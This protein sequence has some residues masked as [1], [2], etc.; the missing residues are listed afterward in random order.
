MA[1]V[2]NIDGQASS[3]AI[4]RDFLV[5]RFADVLEDPDTGGWTVL[6]P[7]CDSGA[8]VSIARTLRA[9]P[10][11]NGHSEKAIFEA[12]RPQDEQPTGIGTLAVELTPARIRA[13]PPRREYLFSVA[14]TGAGVFP[15]GKVGMLAARGGS[16]KSYLLAQLAVSVATGTTWL[17]NGAGWAAK[18]GRVLW[19]PAEEDEE[20]VMRRLHLACKVAGLLT[21]PEDLETICQNIT[22][23]PLCGY[24]VALATQAEFG[25]SGLPETERAAEIR[26]LLRA[27]AVKN[28]PFS[29]LLMDPMSRFSSADV[30]K[31]NA[32]ATRFVQVLE[33][34]TTEE[35]DRPSVLLSHHVGKPHKDATGS[36]P[37]RGVTGIVDAVRWAALLSPKRHKEGPDLLELEVVKTNYA[38]RPPT[39]TLCRPDDWGGAM[40]VALPEELEV[41]TAAD[42]ADLEPLYASIG[43][44]PASGAELARRLSARKEDVLAGVSRLAAL[45]RIKRYGNVWRIAVTVPNGSHGSQEPDCG[46]VPAVPSLKREGNRRGSANRSAESLGNGTEKQDQELVP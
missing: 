44:A 9:M 17:G 15:R 29:L 20:E 2:V 14:K 19:L 40:R 7:I 28:Q 23:I 12:A 4:A 27:A 11:P 39:L 46:S 6:C 18:Q 37:I 26:D 25:K 36:D 21:N 10:C 34:F 30:E 41:S 31:D 33:T 38:R 45:G 35:F 24:D 8:R 16:G 13:E 42:D 3:R 32:A 5:S 22:V 1:E 43:T